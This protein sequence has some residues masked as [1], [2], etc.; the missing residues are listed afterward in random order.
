MRT[1]LWLLLLV[2]AVVEAQ[3]ATTAADLLTRAA[4]TGL[5]SKTLRLTGPRTRDLSFGSRRQFHPIASM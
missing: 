3:N 1:L 2:S 5:E 4:S